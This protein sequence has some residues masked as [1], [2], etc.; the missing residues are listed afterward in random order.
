MNVRRWRA[1]ALLAPGMA[2]GVLLVGTPVGAHVSTN[3]L[4][5]W[6][7]HIK[8]KADPRYLP[9]GTMPPGKTIRGTYW[10]ADTAA[11]GFSLATSEISFGYKLFKTAPTGHFVQAGAIGPPPRCPAT[12]TTAG[13]P[14]AHLH[15]RGLH[16]QRRIRG[17][18]GPSGDGSTF[19]FGTRLWLRSAAAGDFRSFGTWAA[20]SN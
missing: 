7:T 19:R 9:G 1:V 3:W 12:S 5:N 13:R 4:H 6:T 2:I 15:L 16:G 18:N 14:R 10:M 17:F 20:T 11:A 8:P